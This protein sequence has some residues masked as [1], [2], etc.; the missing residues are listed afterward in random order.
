MVCQSRAVLNQMQ[1][2]NKKIEHIDAIKGAVN[3]LVEVPL[4][5]EPPLLLF[6]FWLIEK[7]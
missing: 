2:L 6:F 1:Q 5:F 4:L 7:R 3:N